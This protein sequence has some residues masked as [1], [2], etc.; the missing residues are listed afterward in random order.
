MTRRLAADRPFKSCAHL[1][2]VAVGLA[3]VG[4][5]S[6]DAQ[7]ARV[8]EVA[9]AMDGEDP[10][11]ANVEINLEY[12]YHRA[13]ISRENTQV[14]SISGEARSLLV[15]ELDYSRHKL[16]MLPRLEIGIFRDLAI[17]LEWPV[18]IWDQQDLSYTSGTNK[19][20]STVE[21]DMQSPPT[22]DGWP[23]PG[24]QYGNPGTQREQGHADWNFQRDRNA[25]FKKVRTGI[26]YPVLGARWSPVNNARDPSKPTITVQV[27]YKP[28]FLLPIAQDI[29][30]PESGEVSYYV[31]D[32]AHRFHGMV[33]ISKRFSLLDPYFVA[34][35]YFPFSG[36]DGVM[37]FDPRHDGGFQLGMEI[38]PYEHKE[39]EQKLAID[40][41]FLARYFSQG[42][43]YS[44]VS[45]VLGE[46]TYTDEYLRTGFQ[47]AIF[48]KVFRFATLDLT[49]A[50]MYDTSH[51]LTTEQLG[52]DG[53]CPDPG[54]A[55]FIVRQFE[56]VTTDG[57]VDPDIDSG[58]RNPYFNPVLDTPGRRMRLEESIHLQVMGH[59][60]L[61]F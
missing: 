46:L 15:R 59:I 13:L 17:F 54:L 45:D 58:E 8:T 57:Q 18:V 6:T 10:F 52:C 39:L 48:F 55:G 37:G 20:N 53:G 33:A 61:T 28:G 23:E 32:G 56:D 34:D 24:S 16:R 60:A 29:N 47:A 27:D 43:D 9:D 25:Q 49:G 4:T 26:D 31:A 5:V 44:E 2:M 42:R 36:S 3:T 19:T 14:P 30:D 38:I 50:A 7:A 1:A 21:R 12:T 41:S 35:Y 51:Y 40:F 11:D 22:V